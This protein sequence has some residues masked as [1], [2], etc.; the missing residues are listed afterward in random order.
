MI[1]NMKEPDDDKELCDF[2]EHKLS[3]ME[4]R[5]YNLE[6]AKAVSNIVINKKGKKMPDRKTTDEEILDLHEA[7]KKLTKKCTKMKDFREEFHGINLN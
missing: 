1:K 6:H 3:K 4:R 7:I 5:L 2:N